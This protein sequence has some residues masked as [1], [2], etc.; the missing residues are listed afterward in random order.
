MLGVAA[1]GGVAVGAA[2]ILVLRRERSVQ[3]LAMAVLALA[4]AVSFAIAGDWLPAL[5]MLLIGGVGEAVL[6][7][8]LA[9]GL[10]TSDSPPRRRLPWA[11][12]AA[13]LALLALLLGTGFADRAA[14][15]GRA[16]AVPSLAQVGR[17]LL[18]HSGLAVL[19]VLLLLAAMVVGGSALIQRDTRELAEFHAETVRQRRLEQ[20]QAR[21]RQ[22]EL[23]RAE[24]RAAR[25]GGR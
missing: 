15:I 1:A 21:R 9:R 19:V 18:L 4:L 8:P 20:Q 2:L 6:L 7:A 22:R 14:F 16:G 24:A 13:A 11:A 17:Q 5:G 10:P 23:A 3:L 25:R 12:A